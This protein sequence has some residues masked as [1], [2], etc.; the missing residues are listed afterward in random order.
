[1]AGLTVK[2]TAR[3]STG[4]PLAIWYEEGALKIIGV[5]LSYPHIDKP[6]KGKQNEGEKDKEAKY[7]TKGMLPKRTHGPARELINEFNTWLLA[8]NKDKD[9]NPPSIAREKKYFRD[10]DDAEDP[11]YKD[12]W[13]VSAS[14]ARR[15]SAR[16]T[17]GS[18]ID[19]VEKNAVI[20]DLFQGGHWGNIL[21]RPWYQD[22]QKTGKG[23]GKRLN[24]GLVGVQFLKRDETF[25]E[26]RIDDTE[27]WG[28]ESS[29]SESDSMGGR[30]KYDNLDDV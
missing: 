8:Q 19:P 13:I 30:K 4:K 27:A 10:G 20:A 5:R 26:G 29:E 16:H 9:G 22:G 25:G 24:A 23:F 21:I 1:M 14:E 3:D 6:F 28:D 2:K 18:L 12:H 11:I 15:P 17:D 7:G